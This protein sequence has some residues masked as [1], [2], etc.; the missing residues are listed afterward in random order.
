ME[1]ER[2]YDPV[3]RREYYLKT[4]ELKGRQRASRSKLKKSDWAD[5]LVYDAQKGIK[6]IKKRRAN[7]LQLKIA[8][9]SK[10]DLEDAMDSLAQVRKS[11]MRQGLAGSKQDQVLEALQIK[12]AKEYFKDSPSNS[13]G[14]QLVTDR[15]G[16]LVE[17]PS[18]ISSKQF[19]DLNWNARNDFLPD[20]QNP[21]KDLKGLDFQNPIKKSKANP[22]KVGGDVTSIRPDDKPADAPPKGWKAPKRHETPVEKVLKPRKLPWDKKF[23][24]VK[25]KRNN[26]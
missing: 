11:L 6:N 16:N 15:H 20:L 3:K 7:P 9:A 14:G 19:V 2:K 24:Q 5:K 8:G 4:R 1:T 18:G 26:S 25:D 21:V 22:I 13:P 23:D 12:V 17:L 10:I